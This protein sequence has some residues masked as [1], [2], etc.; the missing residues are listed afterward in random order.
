[1][2]IIVKGNFTV[3]GDQLND[4]SVK[5]VN[6]VQETEKK[7]EEGDNENEEG[8]TENTG[9][10]KTMAT[11]PANPIEELKRKVDMVLPQ[12]TTQR[13]WFPVCTYMM[14]AKIVDEG[15]FKTACSILS[16][17][18]PE[19]KLNAKDLASMYTSYVQKPIEEWTIEKN[20]F[21]SD[22]IFKRL[23]EIGM[24]LVREEGR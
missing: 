20:P 24:T 14:Q 5:I 9:D 3:K 19:T 2:G 16:Q 6:G 18:Y 10:G 1:M 11:P 12:M 13:N 7:G 23:H 8:G 21:N 17:L 15:D 4:F 22:N